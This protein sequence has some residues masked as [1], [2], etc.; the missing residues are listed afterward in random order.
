MIVEFARILA[1][2]PGINELGLVGKPVE[3]V[4]AELDLVRK[5][6]RRVEDRER[7]RAI[8]PCGAYERL[9]DRYPNV[10]GGLTMVEVHVF[11]IKCEVLLERVSEGRGRLSGIKGLA[12]GRCRSDE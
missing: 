4:R 2:S 12:R 8:R 9:C 11:M 5:L 10:C 6:V 1:H 3:P 7:Q